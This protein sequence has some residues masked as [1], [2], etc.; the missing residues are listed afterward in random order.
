MKTWRSGISFLLASSCLLFTGYAAPGASVDA[1]VQAIEQAPDPS[2]AVAAYANGF[3]LDQNNPKLFD[4]Y[5]SRMVELGLP[6]MA[7][8]QAQALTTLQANNGLAWGV[9]AYVDARRAQMPE[10]ISAINL[11]G[12]FA[13]DNK[14]VQHTA[15]ELAAWY[16]LKADKATIPDTAK[17]GLVK[18]RALLD[19]RP[20]YTEAYTTATKAYQASA[21]PQLAPTGS[22]QGTLDQA[23]PAQYAPSVPDAPEAPMA[24]QS[25]QFV[26]PVYA[27]PAPMPAYYP[28]SYFAPDYSGVYLD[29]GP[30]YCYGWGPGWVAPNPW[31]W[32]QP[33]GYWG[34]CN[35]LPFGVS[36]A[37]G[38]FDDFHHFH[39]DGFDRG[40]RFEHGHDATFWHNGSRGRDSFFG[41]PARPGASVAQA[42]RS[43][44]H[45]AS[46]AGGFRDT[47][48]ARWWSGAGEHNS[49]VTTVSRQAQTASFASRGGL[50]SPSASVRSGGIAS[51]LARPNITARSSASTARSAPSWTGS[52]ST[53]RTAPMTSGASVGRNYA[54]PS[55]AAPRSLATPSYR[56][57]AYRAPSFTAPHYTMPG[58]RSFAGSG[59]RRGSTAMA[60][61][62]P[63]PEVSA[64][65][66]AAAVLSAEAFGEAATEAAMEAGAVSVVSPVTRQRR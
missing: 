53:Y 15:G 55:H 39:H 59:G 26:P 38:D 10:A 5:V 4:A 22:T 41:M 52:S 57:P 42:A 33:C 3:A 43:G 19:K 23:A 30:D 8:H 24:P 58:T 31:W 65:F 29:W 21:T 60:H 64:A 32:W 37:F 49:L 46:T 45:S 20:D 13:P 17:D 61:L 51:T 14:F 40:G 27:P 6:E 7:Y 1:A 9:V 35:F 28:D 48:G 44:A 50:A 62:V 54:Y 66:A 18:V 34:G 47:A 16:D 56:A 2:A 36:F 12:Q 11:A 25:D 63:Q